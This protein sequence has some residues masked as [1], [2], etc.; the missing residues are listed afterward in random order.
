MHNASV[1]AWCRV[2]P[3]PLLKTYGKHDRTEF[4]PWSPH[5][6]TRMLDDSGCQRPDTTP[7][8]VCMHRPDRPCLAVVANLTTN[9]TIIFS[10]QCRVCCRSEAHA[11]SRVVHVSDG[12]FVTWGTVRSH[13][14][15][16]RGASRRRLLTYT[17]T[18]RVGRSGRW[19]TG[20]T[21][22]AAHA[23]IH[24]LCACSCRVAL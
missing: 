4:M 5:L 9:P 8:R 10:G 23:H 1:A 2:S 20:K 12:V 3:V 16:R 11:R 22:V 24:G 7:R 19:W 15:S 21:A 6:N 18:P 14:S 17:V 13:C